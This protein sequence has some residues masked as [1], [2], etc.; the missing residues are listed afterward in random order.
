MPLA[1]RSVAAEITN[2]S[3]HSACLPHNTHKHSLAIYYHCD[4]FEGFALYVCGSYF[5]DRYEYWRSCC[6]GD[7]NAIPLL[8]GRAG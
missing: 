2:S 8:A 5:C 4:K 1:F 6:V 7:A 3:L